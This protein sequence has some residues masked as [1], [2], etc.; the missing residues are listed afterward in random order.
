[1][2]K[3]KKKEAEQE[4]KSSIVCGG[5]RAS[6]LPVEAPGKGITS[7]EKKIIINKKKTGK[8]R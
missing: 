5:P 4:M 2:E 7:S 8:T 6:H 1:M 3:E